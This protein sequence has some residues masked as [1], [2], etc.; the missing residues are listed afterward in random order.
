MNV[1][2]KIG[3][4][5]NNWIDSK[6]PSEIG[7]MVLGAVGLIGLGVVVYTKVK[8]PDVLGTVFQAVDEEPVKTGENPTEPIEVECVVVEDEVTDEA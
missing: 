3:S 6:T 7:N 8:G 1:F 5:V 4:A 2:G